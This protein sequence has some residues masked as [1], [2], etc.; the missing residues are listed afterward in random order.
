[1]FGLECGRDEEVGGYVFVDCV[2]GFVDDFDV[3]G[4]GVDY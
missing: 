3:V 4:L 1:M 2:D